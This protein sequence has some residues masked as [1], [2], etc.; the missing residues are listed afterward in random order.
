MERRRYLGRSWGEFFKTFSSKVIRVEDEHMKGYASFIKI[1]E[2]TRPY[3]VGDDTCIADN[4]YSTLT[5]LPDGENYCIEAIYDNYNKIVEW[6]I[7]ITRINAV[8]EDGHPYFDDLYLDVVL[9]PDG[10]ILTFDE[11]EI[12]SAFDSGKITNEDFE[13]AYDVLEKLKKNNI[14]NVKHMEM[15]FLKVQ[16]LFE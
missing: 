10:Q 4:G 15:L 8:D 9:L 6:Y 3:I 13:M 12:K 7:D 1:D 5:F 16:I 14:L 2:V 11:D